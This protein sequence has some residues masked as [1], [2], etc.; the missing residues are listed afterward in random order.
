MLKYLPV[1]FY[2]G[3]GILNTPLKTG[4]GTDETK[5]GFFILYYLQVLHF[6]RNFI[7]LCFFKDL[8]LW[9]RIAHFNETR[10]S[11]SFEIKT[12]FLQLQIPN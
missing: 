5:L 10:V 3:P 2:V 12:L 1:K 11:R 8:M 6:H 9:N 4:R 7:L